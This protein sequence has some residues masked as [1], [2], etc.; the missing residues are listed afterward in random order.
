M[1]AF[2]GYCVC[3]NI[4]TQINKTHDRKKNNILKAK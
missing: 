3:R 2:F 1:F 4:G